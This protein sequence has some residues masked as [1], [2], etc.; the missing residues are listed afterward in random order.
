[1]N[2]VLI[3]CPLPPPVLDRFAA[4]FRTRIA[5]HARPFAEQADGSDAVVLSVDRRLTAAAIAALPPGVRAIATYSVGTD[6][7]DRAALAARGIAVLNTP[8]VLSLAVAELAVFLALGAAR[9]ATESLA[10]VRSGEWQG[11]T[12]TQ[13]IGIELGGRQAGIVGMGRIGREI[14]KRLQALGLRIGY[15]NRRRL[16]PELENG[17]RHHASL[18]SLLA[19]SDL[20]VLALPA[21]PQTDG[22]ID[23]ARIARMKPGAIL[24][25]IARGSLVDDDALIAALASGYLR[26]A[27]L[28]VFR[29]EPKLDQRYLALPNAFLMPHAGSSTLEARQA[30]GETLI[31]GLLALARGETPQNLVPFHDTP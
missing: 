17:A 16:P 27:G 20:V 13:L 3:A 30:M 6:H 25:N 2:S 7:I 1:M 11:W 9:R 28:D 24:V 12:P 22:L 23:A 15:H 31:G 19:D 4:A 18:D 29:N 14:A 10:L 8:D 5:D 21:G 26:A